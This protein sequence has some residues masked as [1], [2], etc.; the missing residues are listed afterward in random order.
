MKDRGPVVA[1]DGPAG[2]GKSTLGRRLAEELGVPYVNTGLMYRA[3]T[4][5]ALRESLDVEDEP[6]LANLA[7]EIRFDL[8]FQSSP[9]SLRVDGRA[10]GED[11]VTP[12]VEGS[13][14]S[15]SRHPAV[16]AVM[17]SEQRRLGARGAVMEGRDIGS[18]VFP[19]ADVKLFLEA[20]PT[21]R[22]RRRERERGDAA[23]EAAAGRDDLDARVNPFVPAPGAIV[24]DTTGRPK[25]DVLAEALEAVRSRVG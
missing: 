21:E 14:S 15:V 8:D 4:A 3:L 2:S 10:P 19:D 16:R 12:E 13:V 22:A 20:A 23:A 18:V 1:I 25:D 11:L 9:P 17:V 5:R 6:A 7:R 24:I